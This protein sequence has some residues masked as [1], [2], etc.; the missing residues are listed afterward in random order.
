[1][2]LVP[3]RLVWT[4]RW[5]KN[6]RFEARRF[7]VKHLGAGAG[8]AGQDQMLGGNIQYCLIKGA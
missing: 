5:N 4:R 3:G 6:D 2:V 1:L 7:T 8:Q